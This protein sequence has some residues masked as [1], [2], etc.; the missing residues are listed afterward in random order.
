MPAG[1]EHSDGEDE[2]PLGGPAR[3]LAGLAAAVA[4]VAV[5][6]AAPGIVSRL[7]L[8]GLA[9]N[10]ALAWGVVA[11]LS[12]LDDRGALPK[13]DVLVPA[14]VPY[15]V[16][17]TLAHRLVAAGEAPAIL[18]HSFLVAAVGVTVATLVASSLNA[19]AREWLGPLDGTRAVGGVG[20]VLAAGLAAR[21]ATPL[22]AI[23]PGTGWILLAAGSVLC[24]VL[25]GQRWVC[26]GSLGEGCRAFA[27]GS[28]LAVT[29]GQ[30]A[31]GVVSYL[32]VRDPFGFLGQTFTEEVPLSA[33]VLET[34][35]PL[36]PL[37]K[38]ALAI[39]I[40]W[41]VDARGQPPSQVARVAVYLLAILLGAGPATFSATQL[42]V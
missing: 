11:V 41:V 8:G 3:D 18:A 20:V 16:L 14:L 23:R 15:L 17:P 5:L 36:Y 32:A 7:P 13:P 39:L 21:I 1:R 26:G 37:G 6:V 38:W 34:A 24:I 31:D 30:L 22:S 9:L 2:G 12:L 19:R 27:T 10:A 29:G 25:V 28:A 40:V 33:F 42:L 4:A 35:G